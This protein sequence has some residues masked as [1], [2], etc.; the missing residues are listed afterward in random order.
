MRR[1]IL[2]RHHARVAFRLTI[3]SAPALF[4]A[5]AAGAPRVP[6]VASEAEWR[7]LAAPRPESLPGAARVAVDDVQLVGDVA[8]GE[9]ADLLPGVE[10]AEVAIAELVNAGLLRRRDV[11]FVERR[12]F[13]I[14]AAAERRA[15]P[16][17][18]GA[19]PAGISPG[20]ELIATAVWLSLTPGQGSVEARLADPS[21]GAIQASARIRVAGAAHPVIV[22]RS[23]VAALLDALEAA[24]RL[25]AWTDPLA[26]ANGTIE[27]ND[28][29]PTAVS[30]FL[31]GLA[32]EERYDWEA[33][34]R[35]YQAALD[36][37]GF[38]EAAT[39]LARTA[40]LRLGGTLGE[41]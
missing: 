9:T 12:R 34:R 8:W 26:G 6:T 17:P 25:P 4:W 5:C 40:R 18:P 30:S 20:A 16:R 10:S 36:Q 31:E 27:G 39:A 13:T 33:A 3:S 29:P 19:P 37:Q 21:S 14:A 7:A 1:A 15:E 2:S 38:F 32:A 11:H 35:G 24:G 41:S 28:I 22:A 23:I